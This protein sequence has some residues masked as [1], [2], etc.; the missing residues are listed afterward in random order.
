[1]YVKHKNAFDTNF[2]RLVLEDL[3]YLDEGTKVHVAAKKDSDFAQCS[4]S[5]PKAHN[6]DFSEHDPQLMMR[7]NETFYHFESAILKNSWKN[8]NIVESFHKE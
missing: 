1:M 5:I 2:K 7:E 4:G 6:D 8:V 3:F